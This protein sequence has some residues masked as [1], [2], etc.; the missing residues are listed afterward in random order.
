[1]AGGQLKNFSSERLQRR[2]ILN[3]AEAFTIIAS[4]RVP[5]VYREYYAGDEA[6]GRRREEGN[7]MRNLFRNR[8]A[9]GGRTVSDPGV[10]QKADLDAFLQVFSQGESRSNGID[11]DAGASDLYCQC[12]NFSDVNLRKV[13]GI[14]REYPSVV[15]QYVNGP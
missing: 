11:R 2:R 8:P 7:C 4:D 15:H 5:T 1:M 12:L 9:P 14:G 13:H 6:R 3:G 10:I